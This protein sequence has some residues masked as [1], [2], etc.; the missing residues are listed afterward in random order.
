M[1]RRGCHD[2]A[3]VVASDS[4]MDKPVAFWSKFNPLFCENDRVFF[5]QSNDRAWKMTLDQPNLIENR[6]KN[7]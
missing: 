4:E 7:R 5:I 3:Q 1:A 2:T 6:V